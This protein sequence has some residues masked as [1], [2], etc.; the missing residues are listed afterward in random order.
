MAPATDQR[1][2][3][4]KRARTR[5]AVLRAAIACIAEEG[6]ASANTARIAERCDVSW[7][8]IQYHFGDRTGLFLALIEWGFTALKDALAGLHSSAPDLRSRLESLV[9]GTWALM[10]RPP[11]R[12]VLEVLLQLGR[13]PDSA[14]AV[15]ERTRQMRGQLREVWRKALPEHA[16]DSVDR[17][18]RL[19]ITSLQGL[20]LEQAL[21][22]KRAAHARDRK[23]LIETLTALLATPGKAAPPSPSRSRRTASSPTAPS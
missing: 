8:V 2:A 23:A 20:A 21:E 10:E 13:E 1:R 11:Y 18:E 9:E 7:G 22:G 17:V 19:A 4:R 5:E 16:P 12:A 14:A 3:T 6:M 15:R